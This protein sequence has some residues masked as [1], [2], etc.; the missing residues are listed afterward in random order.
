[1]NGKFR[2]LSK[3]KYEIVSNVG[4]YEDFSNKLLR[5]GFVTLRC[6]REFKDLKK[7]IRYK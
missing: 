5:E 4:T 1:M 6:E 3:G 2:I 7:C